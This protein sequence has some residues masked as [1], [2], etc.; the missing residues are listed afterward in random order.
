MAVARGSRCPGEGCDVEGTELAVAR[1]VRGCVHYAATYRDNPDA[2]LDPREAYRLAHPPSAV[3]ARRSP[4]KVQD[5][6]GAPQGVAVEVWAWPQ[7]IAD[8]S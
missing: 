8:I 6:V 4:S 3:A 7:T 2:V 5:V 1:H